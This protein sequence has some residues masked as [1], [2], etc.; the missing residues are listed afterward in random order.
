MLNLIRNLKNGDL[1]KNPCL[2]C[3]NSI[4]FEKN[5]NSFERNNLLAA[6]ERQSSLLNFSYRDWKK[7]G[8]NRKL[9]KPF[10]TSTKRKKMFF[11]VWENIDFL[12]ESVT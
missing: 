1:V 2:F 6:C 3:S 4:W 7:G 12:L 5:K 10:K 11:V 8:R 9:Q